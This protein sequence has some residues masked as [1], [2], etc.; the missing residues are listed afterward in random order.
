MLGPQIAGGKPGCEG[1][2]IRQCNV[3][4][5]RTSARKDPGVFQGGSGDLLK[6]SEFWIA[7]G[8]RLGGKEGNE[9]PLN[10]PHSQCAQLSQLSYGWYQPP[11]VGEQIGWG[12]S[13]RLHGLV[14]AQTRVQSPGS[15]QTARGGGRKERLGVAE[16][17]EKERWA[18]PGEKRRELAPRS[19]GEESWG[20]MA[21]RA[22]N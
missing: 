15:P 5:E 2:G 4:G 12:R 6:A 17:W 3:P 16:S 22:R 10:A 8:T 7:R 9:T 19:S 11:F 14:M 1:P 21:T 20:R 18:G 13:V